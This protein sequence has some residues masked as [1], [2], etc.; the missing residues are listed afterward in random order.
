MGGGGG[1]ALS[2]NMWRPVWRRGASGLVIITEYGL[3]SLGSST[4]ASGAV[5]YDLPQGL[6]ANQQAQARQNVYAAPFDAMAYSGMQI[7]G[8]A[9]VI[10]EGSPLAIISS[11]NG[12]V[13]PC[14]GWFA[15]CAQASGAINM[16]AYR[17]ASAISGY[18]WDVRLAAGNS[19][20]TAATVNDVVYLRQAIEGYRVARLGWG[21]AAASPLSYAFQ[22]YASVAGTF[23]IRLFNSAVNRIYYKEHTVTAGYNWVVATI[24][25]DTSGTWL[26][27]NNVGLYLDIVFGGKETSPAVPNAWGGSPAKAQTTGSTNFMATT[28]NIIAITGFI[29]LPGVEVPS[30]R[31]RR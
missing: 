28:S 25:G 18:Q 13:R 4:A 7:N 24:P 10:Q 19:N 11:S 1:G 9:D 3:T 16:Q 17:N 31:A 20:F 23:F 5:R 2:N 21:T 8:N 29:I 22:L 12:V 27:D 14:D 26:A 15:S 6:T 30:Q